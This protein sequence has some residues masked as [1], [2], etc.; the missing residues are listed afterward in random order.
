MTHYYI[1]DFLDLAQ[2]YLVDIR[3]FIFSNNVMGE[4]DF[5][6]QG[7]SM[8]YISECKDILMTAS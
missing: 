3:R 7:K 2:G 1:L 5:V 8:G 6:I 4:F